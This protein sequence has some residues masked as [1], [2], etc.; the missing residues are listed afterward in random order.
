MVR[1]ARR[2]AIKQKQKQK[3]TVIVNIGAE[4]W[5]R[6]ALA[7]RPR[8]PRAKPSR[9]AARPVVQNAPVVAPLINAGFADHYARVNAMAI[10]DFRRGIAA[11]AR[12]TPA[13]HENEEREQARAGVLSRLVAE[14]DD[15]RV[16]NAAVEARASGLESE[17]LS[18]KATLEDHYRGMLDDQRR[19]HVRE[20]EKASSTVQKLV[21]EKNAKDPETIANLVEAS[22]RLRAERDKQ[23]SRTLSLSKRRSSKGGAQ[24]TG[25]SRR[26]ERIEVSEAEDGEE[27][28]KS[29]DWAPP[30]EEEEPPIVAGVGT[31][32]AEMVSEIHKLGGTTPVTEPMSEADLREEQRRKRF[33]GAVERLRN[34]LVNKWTQKVMRKEAVNL[35]ITVGRH[36]DFQML[37]ERMADIVQANKDRV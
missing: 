17:I 11:A 34:T 16:Q 18:Q 5:P 27:E 36:P 13:Q 20:I 4:G 37:R 6:R 23:G 30:L 10:D 2:A 32:T 7:L 9:A 8:R 29:S 1:K 14:A 3:Q 31:R 22:D 26:V 33:N 25:R 35:G 15:L 24:S 19:R 28:A 12:E 21:L